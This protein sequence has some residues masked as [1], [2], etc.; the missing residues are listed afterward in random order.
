MRPDHVLAARHLAAIAARVA[1]HDD[2]RLQ[3]PQAVA[4]ELLADGFARSESRAALTWP[5]VVELVLVVPGAEGSTLT[6]SQAPG[7]VGALARSLVSWFRREAPAM[8]NSS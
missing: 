8:D 4:T 2:D 7:V 3:V 5:D 6:L 1:S